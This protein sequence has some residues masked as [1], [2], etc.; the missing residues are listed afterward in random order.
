MYFISLN[1]DQRNKMLYIP[2]LI[3][4]LEVLLV[5]VPVLLTVAYVTVALSKFNLGILYMLAVSSLSIYGILL[6][7]WSANSK[8]YFLGSLKHYTIFNIIIG[9][10]DYYKDYRNIINNNLF[11]VSYIS[12]FTIFF[13]SLIA[14]VFQTRNTYINVLAI[15]IS[16]GIIICI[17]ILR[18]SILHNEYIVNRISANIIF[19]GL[20]CLLGLLYLVFYNYISVDFFYNYNFQYIKLGVLFFAC[21]FFIIN[22]IYMPWNKDNFI[23]LVLKLSYVVFTISFSGLCGILFI[24]LFAPLVIDIT[25]FILNMDNHGLGGNPGPAGNPNPGVNP[26]PAGNPGPGENPGPGGNPGL[27]G[28]PAPDLATIQAKVQWRWDNGFRSVALFSTVPVH[29]FN[30]NFTLDEITYLSNKVRN[31]GLENTKP[32]GVLKWVDGDRKGFYRVVRLRDDQQYPSVGSSPVRPSGE[33]RA[34]LDSL[35]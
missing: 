23:Y 8:Y 21:T 33:F 22:F 9:I 17:F 20:L 11:L 19:F 1:L 6:A 16:L 10:I 13:I 14:V 31:L 29:N 27:A 3:S 18:P 2:T 15:Y 32:F 26:G 34:F 35:T 25:D 28:N 4:I 24:V 5:T 12:I 7:G 30:S